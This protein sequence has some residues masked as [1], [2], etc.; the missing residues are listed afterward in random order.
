[1]EVK[2]EWN[3]GLSFNASAATG[4]TVALRSGSETGFTPMEMIAIGLAGCTAMDVIAILEKK[5]QE[6]TAFEVRV[7]A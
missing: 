2:V 1:M 4:A 6:V 5:R 3:E 7:H